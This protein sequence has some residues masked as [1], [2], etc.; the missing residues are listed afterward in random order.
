M[1]TYHS[2]VEQHHTDWFRDD[3][4]DFPCSQDFLLH[5]LILYHSLDDPNL[6]LHM[7]VLVTRVRLFY[8]LHIST[9][10]IK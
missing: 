10:R 3:R 6:I 8:K 5:I 4:I 9:S 7:W 1:K 2:L